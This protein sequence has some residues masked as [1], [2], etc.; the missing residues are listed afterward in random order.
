MIGGK[1]V[2]D[3]T[4]VDEFDRFELVPRCDIAARHCP[5]DDRAAHDLP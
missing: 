1:I 5:V 3:V 2:V 4:S